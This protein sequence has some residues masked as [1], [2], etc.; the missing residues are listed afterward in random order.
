MTTTLANTSAATWVT[1]AALIAEHSDIGSECALR[2][3]YRYASTRYLD[4][5]DVARAVIDG[6]L[7]RGL[8][9]HPSLAW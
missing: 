8:L 6:S 2:A 3:M 4:I 1:A 9:A 7:S 5:D